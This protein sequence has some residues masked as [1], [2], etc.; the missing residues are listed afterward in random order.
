MQQ[1]VEADVGLTLVEVRLALVLNLQPLS[2]EVLIEITAHEVCWQPQ[3]Q[4]CSY[5]SSFHLD[6]LESYAWRGEVI[7]WAVQAT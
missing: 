5:W 2:G 1:G 7:P 6:R 4:R 3:H